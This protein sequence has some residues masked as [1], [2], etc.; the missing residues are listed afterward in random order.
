VSGVLSWW[1]YLFLAQKIEPWMVYFLAL[2]DSLDEQSLISFAERLSVPAPNTQRLTKER[3]EL[4]WILS[5]L[6]R[7]KIGKPSEI[8]SVLSK[9][10]M[11]S[12]LFMMGKAGHETTRRAISEFITKLRHVRP[13]MTGR[14]LKEMG[15]EPG[16]IFGA[17]LKSLREARLDGFVKNLDEEK[18]F[19]TTF[20]PTKNRS[21]SKNVAKN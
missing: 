20:F 4:R 10:S 19:V 8:Y 18:K 15:Y 9:L 7:E 1:K 16:P 11:E 12:L 3:R 21:A 13:L 5:L 6:E 14:N 17:I 2:T